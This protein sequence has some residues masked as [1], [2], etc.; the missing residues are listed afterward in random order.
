MGEA[1]ATRQP[2]IGR[3]MR[4]QGMEGTDPLPAMV[5]KVHSPTNV[6]LK[7]FQNSADPDA[8]VPSVPQGAG[9]NTWDWPAQV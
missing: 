9:G 7:V 8:Y 5:V 4:Y 2:S 6:N 1:N 3:I